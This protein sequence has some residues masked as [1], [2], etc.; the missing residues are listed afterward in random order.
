MDSLQTKVRKQKNGELTFA[1]FSDL[2]LF[3]PRTPTAWIIHSFW[4]AFPDTDASNDVDYLILAGDVFDHIENIPS[5]EFSLVMGWIS[6]LLDMCYRRNIRLRILEGTPSHDRKQSHVFIEIAKAKQ[7]RCP[8]VRYIQDLCIDY[9]EAFDFHILY[10][11]DE[12]HHDH[13]VVWELTK[14]RLREAG[15][16]SV[17]VGIMHGSMDFQV[18]SF[19]NIRC[20]NSDNY[21]SIVK[22]F[23]T[24]GHEHV[25][26]VNKNIYAQGSLERLKHG[27]ED[28]K[29][30]FRI[31]V[32]DH[33]KATQT[34][35]GEFNINKRAMPYKKVDVAGM[36]YEDALNKVTKIA[37][38]ILNEPT[39]WERFGIAGFIRLDINTELY[40]QGLLQACGELFPQIRWTKENVKTL[41]EEKENS[42]ENDAMDFS[43]SDIQPI[44]PTSLPSLLRD[45][46]PNLPKHKDVDIDAIIKTFEEVTHA[47]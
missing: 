9:E 14:D 38:K 17:E 25:K 24:I 43:L 2:H 30:H 34:I 3:H 29:G 18:P 16:D 8:D 42:V 12:F 10:V 5:S 27:E 11:P 4:H 20:H 21:A 22:W 7:E 33:D 23:T 44:T 40:S 31:S 28:P 1:T 45:K 6:K 26:S 19:R 32:R 41:K 37:E 15:L 47:T 39:D 46:L 35:H 13:D 36:G